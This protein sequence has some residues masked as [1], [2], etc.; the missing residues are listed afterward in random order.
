MCR[1]TPQDA[2]WIPKKIRREQHQG[3]YYPGFLSFEL[4]RVGSA[5]PGTYWRFES[6]TC[7]GMP[8]PPTDIL[9]VIGSAG[10]M[11]YGWRRR[12]EQRRQRPVGPPEAIE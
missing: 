10:T 5:F 11:A 8:E 1:S 12:R 6:T 9:L 7:V 3:T 2:G 4:T